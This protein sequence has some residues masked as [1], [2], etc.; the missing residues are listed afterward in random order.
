MRSDDGDLM[1]YNEATARIPE[2]V[3]AIRVR[4][5]RGAAPLAG[6]FRQIGNSDQSV[7]AGE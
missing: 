4:K 2:A 7:L 6:D 1:I 3:E 5:P